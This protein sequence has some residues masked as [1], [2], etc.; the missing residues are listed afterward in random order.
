MKVNI[1]QQP[2]GLADGFG[3][4]FPYVRLS[5]TD[6]CN[7][8]CGCCLPDG[9]KLDKKA[10]GFYEA[11][12]RAVN[13]SIDACLDVGMEAVKVNTVLLKGVNDHEL[14]A[15]TRYVKDKPVSLRFD[16]L[17]NLMSFK[18]SS[19]FLYQGSSGATPHLASIG[20]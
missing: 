6:V 7:F 5:V 16:E 1:A 8:R 19:H 17:L 12:I 14:S 11:S 13:V 3:R 10:A 15:F 18:K 9:Y 20:G 4:R 2:A